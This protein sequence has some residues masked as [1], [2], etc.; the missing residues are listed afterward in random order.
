MLKNLK[1]KMKN[2]RNKSY[3]S[4]TPCNISKGT[5]N[6]TLENSRSQTKIF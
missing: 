6:Y 1:A 2:A 5:Q 4:L 3:A